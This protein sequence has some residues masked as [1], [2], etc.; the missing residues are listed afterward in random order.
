M[1]EKTKVKSFNKNE[2]HKDINIQH[3]KSYS[4]QIRNCSH[5]IPTGLHYYSRTIHFV[6]TIILIRTGPD[7]LQPASM[8]TGNWETHR[9]NY[10]GSPKFFFDLLKFRVSKLVI[11]NQSTSLT[12]IVIAD[13]CE[14][15]GENLATKTSCNSGNKIV[16]NEIF[17]RSAIAIIA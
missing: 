10:F 7:E 9:F 5:L 6:H 3:S 1:Q 4:G 12:N 11:H 16:A 14:E 15:V 13:D 17:C 8:E 2:K